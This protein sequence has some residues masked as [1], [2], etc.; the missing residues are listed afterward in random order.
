MRK[1]ILCIAILLSLTIVLPC[2]A[3]EVTE[4]EKNNTLKKAQEF[5][6]GDV[7]TANLSTQK[8]V[9][10]FKIKVP[11]DGTLHLTFE[12]FDQSKAVYS[13]SWKLTVYGSD[14]KK[15]LLSGSLPAQKT[16]QFEV[17]NVTEGMVY[18][19]FEKVSG[20]NPLTN[21]YSKQSFNISAQ[22]ACKEH[23]AIGEWEITKN[24]TCKEEGEQVRRCSVCNW[25]VETEKLGKTS[26]SYTKW[27]VLEEATITKDGKQQRTCVYC[28]EV[29][30]T[31]YTH[32][33]AVVL[34]FGVVGAIIVLIVVIVIVKNR[35]DYSSSRSSYSGRSYSSGSY[36]S[37]NYSNGDSYGG[38]SS[39][40]SSDTSTYDDP[41]HYGWAPDYNPSTNTYTN[42]E[43]VTQTL[44]KGYVVGED[45]YVHLDVSDM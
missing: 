23:G 41:T 12:P 5:A 21:G 6:L 13:Y 31:D 44:E 7:M 28:G 29:F 10:C 43:G 42:G 18:L 16:L 32:P 25:A 1:I 3:A 38:Y 26:H 34:A 39:T 14:K 35:C 11:F 15:E 17:K 8:D 19:K 24:P 36:G 2:S 33:M 30:T 9:D 40:Y 4:K 20:G 45:G 27:E 22:I 37:S